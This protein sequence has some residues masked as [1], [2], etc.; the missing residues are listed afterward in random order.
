MIVTFINCKKITERV[1]LSDNFSNNDDLLLETE[2]TATG[3]KITSGTWGLTDWTEEQQKMATD[4]LNQQI[5]STLSARDLIVKDFLNKEISQQEMYEQLILLNINHPNLR[6]RYKQHANLSRQNLPFCKVREN[7]EVAA[8][9]NSHPELDKFYKE[10]TDPLPTE[11]KNLLASDKNITFNENMAGLPTF[12]RFRLWPIDWSNNQLKQNINQA[13]VTE[14]ITV[15]GISFEIFFSEALSNQSALVMDIIDKYY[16]KLRDTFFNG[17][18]VQPMK[19]D[20]PF[21]IAIIHSPGLIVDLGGVASPAHSQMAASF[22]RTGDSQGRTYM[23]I[24]LARGDKKT[25]FKR[26]TRT[27]PETSY[28]K[29]TILHEL[30]HALQIA[31]YPDVYAEDPL[32]E[33]FAEWA[34]YHLLPHEDALAAFRSLDNYLYHTEPNIIINEPESR[35]YGAWLLFEFMYQA[36]NNLHPIN[37][38]LKTIAAGYGFENGLEKALSET[39]AF[40]SFDIAWQSFATTNLNLQQ[41]VAKSP[42]VFTYP[43]PYSE[44][45]LVGTEDPHLILPNTEGLV[46]GHPFAVEFATPIIT[47]LGSNYVFAL[48]PWGD[49]ETVDN[50][51]EIDT[52]NFPGCVSIYSLYIPPLQKNTADNQPEYHVLEHQQTCR[53]TKLIFTNVSEEHEYNPPNFFIFVLTHKALNGPPITGKIRMQAWPLAKDTI[54]KEAG[55]PLHYEWQRLENKSDRRYANK[56]IFDAVLFHD[57]SNFNWE[58]ADLALAPYA[59]IFDVS[60]KKLDVTDGAYQK[61][62]HY[63]FQSHA[64]G[65]LHCTIEEDEYENECVST[66]IRGNRTIKIREGDFVWNMQRNAF[67]NQPIESGWYRG[68]FLLRSQTDKERFMVPV[69]VTSYCCESAREIDPYCETKVSHQL[70]MCKLPVVFGTFNTGRRVLY[71]ED[72]HQYALEFSTPPEYIDHATHLVWSLTLPEE[73]QFPVNMVDEQNGPAHLLDEQR[74]PKAWV[75]DWIDPNQLEHGILIR[76]DLPLWTQEQYDAMEAWVA[77][78]IESDRSPQDILADLID[79]YKLPEDISWSD[80]TNAY[81]N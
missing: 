18:N 11:S 67:A 41:D 17:K 52:S 16:T 42:Q 28:Q 40:P 81:Y 37:A 63:L 56:T 33:A 6:N 38:Y 49:T 74:Q 23:V 32:M 26:R 21:Q 77:E 36:A 20:G 57:I 13:N 47:P 43:D 76:A 30:V 72:R 46:N 66:E 80:L 2:P 70:R 68:K 24:N 4:I 73:E 65:T 60:F 53:P 75:I 59:E 9:L 64:G 27:I 51:M 54:S 3:N 10:H 45:Y 79:R 29:M 22:V 5:E 61:P 50:A 8:I 25:Q 78:Q 48:N 34:A 19:K 71:E 7:Q 35:P 69:E 39:K 44:E 12:N 31:Y 14:Q 1:K 62:D 15:D 55:V 58:P